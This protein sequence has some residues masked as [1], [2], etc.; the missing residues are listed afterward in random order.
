V[1][2]CGVKEGRGREHGWGGAEEEE[3]A[4]AASLRVHAVE[5]EVGAGA[6]EPRLSRDNPP[7]AVVAGTM[8]YARAW[9]EGRGVQLVSAGAAA[10]AMARVESAE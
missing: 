4:L 6:V 7:S 8:A 3:R 9:N 5:V 10:R 1:F 2:G